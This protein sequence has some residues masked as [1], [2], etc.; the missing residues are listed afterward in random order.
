MEERDS[1]TEFAITCVR[2]WA[3]PLRFQLS[4]TAKICS[5]VA[6]NKKC[7]DKAHFSQTGV[8]ERDLKFHV[9]VLCEDAA[10]QKEIK[11]NSNSGRFLS[12]AKR[13]VV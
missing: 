7:S 11:S 2:W 5:P 12:K 6:K 4:I 10:S 3:Q 8:K 9:M 13:L 1:P